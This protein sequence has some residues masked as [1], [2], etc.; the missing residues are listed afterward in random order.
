[1]KFLTL[2]WISLLCPSLLFAEELRIDRYVEAVKRQDIQIK[3]FVQQRLQT[4]FNV[5]LNLP[6][7]SWTLALTKEYGI[8]TDDKENTSETS[9]SLTKSAISTGTDLEISYETNDLADREESVKSVTVEQN[10]IQNAFGNQNRKL[11]EMLGEQN[12]IIRWQVV[13]S[14]E[15][16]LAQR[17]GDYLDFILAHENFKTAK[18]LLDDVKTLTRE[19]RQRR[20]KSIAHQVD[21]DRALA[22]T[23]EYQRK[24]LEAKVQVDSLRKS[25]LASLEDSNLP[26]NFVPAGGVPFINN[27]NTFKDDLDRFWKDART[28]Q[29]YQSSQKAANLDIAVKEQELYPE[30]KLILGY[31]ED[32][33]QRFSSRVNRGET[34]VGFNLSY[35]F[36]NS[37]DSAR[38]EQSKYLKQQLQLQIQLDQGRLRAKL[39]DLEST[40]QTHRERVQ[41]L[42]QQV[43]VLRRLVSG[44]RNRFQ[45]GG[46]S[47]KTLIDAQNKFTE[48]QYNLTSQEVQLAKSIIEWKKITDTLVEETEVLD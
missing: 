4:R 48:T 36:D 35:S 31:S 25:L 29:I 38:L 27:F 11:A 19:V 40:I 2:L 32:D 1:M 13:E 3:K 6:D 15:D 12:Q 33:S 47:L 5:D 21:V 28:F 26:E 9:A 43:K 45:R 23:L 30:G 20:S 22:E 17:I 42:E 34:I 18:G 10:L 7:Q 41:L 16:Y 14:Y 46:V 39:E 44:E 8:A 37:I 24:V